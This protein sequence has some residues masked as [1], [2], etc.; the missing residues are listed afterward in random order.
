M[1]EDPVA[2]VGD[3]GLDVGDASDGLLGVVKRS[4]ASVELAGRAGSLA[5]QA[6]EVALMGVDAAP[7]LGEGGLVGPAE[8]AA[9]GQQLE[10]S[11]TV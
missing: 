2:A 4:S 5:V 8:P 3:S 10:T 7:G 1:A 9:A 6:R 11:S